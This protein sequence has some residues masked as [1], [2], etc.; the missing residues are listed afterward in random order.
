MSW[1]FGK[2]VSRRRFL[3]RGGP[4][5]LCNRGRPRFRLWPFSRREAKALVDVSPSPPRKR[6]RPGMW[7]A[8]RRT[9]LNLKSREGAL[10][11]A[12]SRLFANRGCAPR[13]FRLREACGSGRRFGEKVPPQPTSCPCRISRAAAVILTQSAESSAGGGVMARSVLRS[14]RTPRASASWRGQVAVRRYDPESSTV[15]RPKTYR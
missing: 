1:G 12:P 7:Q 15:C 10:C 2:P 8:G 4:C 3:P 11:R 9:A 6:N 5:Q 14:A 13:R